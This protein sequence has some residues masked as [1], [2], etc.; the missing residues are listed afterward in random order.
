MRTPSFSSWLQQKPNVFYLHTQFCLLTPKWGKCRFF[1]PVAANALPPSP[2]A[3]AAFP[4]QQPSLTASSSAFCRVTPQVSLLPRF[5]HADARSFLGMLHQS[6]LREPLSSPFQRQVSGWCYIARLW[7][8]GKEPRVQTYWCVYERAV[9]IE[10]IFLSS[11]PLSRYSN[12][13]SNLL[14]HLNQ[15]INVC[16]EFS[17]G[18]PSYYLYNSRVMCQRL[19]LDLSL[20]TF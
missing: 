3:C 19:L 5:P 15:C 14:L 4:L 9:Q 12:S 10:N 18:F 8:Q 16:I 20:Y 7:Q 2:V 1:P 6:L 13:K 17:R 11:H